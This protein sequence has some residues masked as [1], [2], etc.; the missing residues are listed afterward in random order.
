[1]VGHLIDGAPELNLCERPCESLNG[2]WRDTDTCKMRGKYCN[3]NLKL[4]DPTLT[5][6]ALF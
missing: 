1:M 6:S 2:G 3:T 5:F 4:T